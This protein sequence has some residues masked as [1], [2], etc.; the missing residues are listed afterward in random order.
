MRPVRETINGAQEN[1]TP[2]RM[3]GEK[4]TAQAD[5]LL[6]LVALPIAAVMELQKKFG[7][8]V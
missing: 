1:R 6:L 7:R 5:L 4:Q 8:K 2:A 3:Q